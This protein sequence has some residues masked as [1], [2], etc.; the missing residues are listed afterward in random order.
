MARSELFCASCDRC[1]S[2]KT[3]CDG[4]K[5]CGTCMLNYMRKHKLSNVDGIDAS[6][7]NCVFSPARRRGPVPGVSSKQPGEDLFCSL[8]NRDGN[9]SVTSTE[10]SKEHSMRPSKEQSGKEARGGHVGAGGGSTTMTSTSAT[11]NADV[12]GWRMSGNGT[13][14]REAVGNSN[15]FSLP[16]PLD[17]RAATGQEQVLSTLGSIGNNLFNLSLPLFGINGSGGGGYYFSGGWQQQQQQQDIISTAQNSA[18]KQ[19]AY[20]QL[21]QLQQQ[22]QMQKH[23]LSMNSVALSASQGSNGSGGSQN[24]LTN[25][26]IAN[27]VMVGGGNGRFKLKPTE[28][29]HPQVPSNVGAT[30]TSS[31][32]RAIGCLHPRVL[33]YLPLT[34]P[35][36]PSGMHLRACYTLSFGG[37]FGLSTVPTDEDYCRRFAPLEPHQ[38]PKFDVAV[39]QAARFAELSIGALTMMKNGDVELVVKLANASVLCLLSCVEEQFHPCLILDIARVFFFH[40]TVRL[41][42]GD[43][44]C[45][46]KYRRACLWYLSQLNVSRPSSFC[47]AFSSDSLFKI[48]LT[49]DAITRE[50]P[51]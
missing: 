42:I 51:G 5:P 27:E 13:D 30:A 32:K 14:H 15:N 35:T 11:T 45:Y 2:R 36:N 41:Y 6:L 33:Q 23:R 20:V 21:L 18:Q 12:N 29:I 28:Q 17:Q 48:N 47:D 50:L 37:L 31:R 9:A 10:S 25:S 22:V 44:K 3:R 7:F 46:F 1:R 4:K 8:T 49:H 26:F 39:L 43:M 19:L 16:L 34:N 40:S 24:S 38:L